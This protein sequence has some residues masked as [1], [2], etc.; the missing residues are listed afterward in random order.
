MVD[1]AVAPPRVAPT[2][3][4]RRPWW[5]T[6][7]FLA[8][9]LF[10]VVLVISRVVYWRTSIAYRPLQLAGPA[11]AAVGQPT[12]V[13][14]VPGGL[15]STAVAG[16]EQ[17]LEFPIRNDGIHALDINSVTA[18][19]GAVA[20]VQWAANFVQ[21]GKRVPSPTH[22]LPVHV[23]GHA[24][25]NLQLLVR[26]PACSKGTPRYLSAVVTIHWHAMVSPHAT[27]LDLLG[28]SGQRI[29]LCAG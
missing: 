1:T 17:L 27:R 9:L 26:Q 8:P 19:D 2:P 10:L 20:G 11:A 4:R 16:T 13:D 5:R 22:T 3:P 6:L 12:Q 15:R 24:I 14:L 29:A 23:P 18:L 25:V 21:N 7:W 28:G